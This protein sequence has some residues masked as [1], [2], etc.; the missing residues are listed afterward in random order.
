M[1][2]KDF[3]NERVEQDYLC[4]EHASISDGAINTN[5]FNMC[6][7]G[8]CDDIIDQLVDQVEDHMDTYGVTLLEAIEELGIPLID[9]ELANTLN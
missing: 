8:H 4:S 5:Q 9:K 3:I 2:I 6:E 7:G 1:D